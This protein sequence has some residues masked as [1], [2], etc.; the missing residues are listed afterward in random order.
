MPRGATGC[1]STV[2]GCQGPL[3][4]ACLR[5]VVRDALLLEELDGDVDVD[6]RAVDEHERLLQV[7]VRVVVREAARAAPKLVEDALRVRGRRGGQLGDLP[8][9]ACEERGVVGRVSGGRKARV[10]GGGRRQE[11]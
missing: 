1:G 11:E 8:A 4:T 9:R 2:W 7:V 6:V 10:S 5:P 3:T